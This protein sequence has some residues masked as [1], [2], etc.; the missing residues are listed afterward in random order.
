MFAGMEQSPV[1][2]GFDANDG[3]SVF[4]DYTTVSNIIRHDKEE[5]AKRE[6]RIVKDKKKAEK[7]DDTIVLTDYT[8]VHLQ[9][10]VN[11][12]VHFLMHFSVLIL[13]NTYCLGL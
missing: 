1:G 9:I 13:S 3:D 4:S 8:Y 5:E 10:W 7:S 11:N 6:E 12:S 2:A